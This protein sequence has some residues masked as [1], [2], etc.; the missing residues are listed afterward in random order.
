MFNRIQEY[1]TIVKNIQTYLKRS[2][3]CS[4][5]FKNKYNQECSNVFN[6]IQEQSKT[7]KQIQTVLKH[8]QRIFFNKQLKNMQSIQTHQKTFEDIRTTPIHT[9][10]CSNNVKTTIL[11]N[12]R[13]CSKKIKQYSKI[14]QHDQHKIKHVQT[15]LKPKHTQ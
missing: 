1:H 5:N 6:N 7:S 2:Q 13:M 8:A 15:N 4:N 14:S 11:K 3:T 10:P 12:S 9:Q